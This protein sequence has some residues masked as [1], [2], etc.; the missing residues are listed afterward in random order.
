MRAYIIQYIIKVLLL[1][2][3][4][5]YIG[6]HVGY[7]QHTHVVVCVYSRLTM[8]NHCL[9]SE[10]GAVNVYNHYEYKIYIYIY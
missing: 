7:R 8:Q 6:R 5:Y 1:Y 3:C 4:I 9:N 2:L 10:L